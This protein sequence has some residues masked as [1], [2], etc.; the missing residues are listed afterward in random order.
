M[1]IGIIGCGKIFNAYLKGSRHYSILDLARVADLDVER[2]KA[3]AAEHDVPRA[4]SVDELL[5]DDDVELVV[6]LTIPGAHAAVDRAVL[7]AGKHVHSE[8]PLAL[9]RVEIDPVVTLADEKGLRLGCAP[10]TFLGA[11][12][13]RCRQLYDQG[14]VG[15]AVAATAFIAG[16]G[17]ETWHP[18]PEFYYKPGGGPLFDMGPYYLTALVSILGP[19]ERVCGFSGRAWAQREITSEPLAGTIVDVEVDT[20]YSASLHFACGAIANLVASF[21]VKGGHQLPRLEIYG[22][23]G[24]MALPDPNRFDG[25][26]QVRAAGRT[27]EWEERELTHADVG[28]RGAGAA[29]I[30][31]AIDGDRPHR[32]SA[33]LARHVLEVMEAVAS[34]GRDGAVVAVE[35]RCERPAPVPTGLEPGTFD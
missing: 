1:R 14:A 10:D 26:V 16:G 7:E 13:Q 29:D 28:M 8:K 21:D 11:G 17:H 24:S 5:T 27:T 23:E 34:C 18:S 20:H 12:L 31:H 2:A 32:C 25:P 19:V 15:E 9:S 35:S 30:A 4:G 6:N 33:E 3:V 22:R